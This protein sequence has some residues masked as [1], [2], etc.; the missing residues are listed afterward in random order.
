MSAW[1]LDSKL[2]TYSNDKYTHY[3]FAVDTLKKTQPVVP[4][5]MMDYIVS[6]FV[7]MRRDARTQTNQTFTSARTLLAL[8]RLSTALV[9]VHETL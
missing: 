7:E 2:S 6:A 8:L 1:F 4:E 3:Y 9:C 5:A